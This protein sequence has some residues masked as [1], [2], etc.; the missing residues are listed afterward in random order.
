VFDQFDPKRTSPGGPQVGH[1]GDAALVFVVEGNCA[2]VRSQCHEKGDSVVGLCQS[3]NQPGR[4]AT[5]LQGFDLHLHRSPACGVNPRRYGKVFHRLRVCIV[6][7][8]EGAGGDT[9]TEAPGP[10]PPEPYGRGQTAKVVLHGPLFSGGQNCSAPSPL[11]NRE[12]P[13]CKR[14][15]AP[16]RDPH[17]TAS[18]RFIGERCDGAAVYEEFHLLRSL[19]NF[20]PEKSGAGFH[21]FRNRDRLE[22]FQSF[23]TTPEQCRRPAGLHGEEIIVLRVRIQSVEEPGMG[24]GI[25]FRHGNVD[26]NLPAPILHLRR[27]DMIVPYGGTVGGIADKVG[28]ILHGS[29]PGP[30][31]SFHQKVCQ[32]PER[33]LRHCIAL[34]QKQEKHQDKY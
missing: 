8:G 19:Q 13:K 20:K 3:V 4:S 10:M 25:A 9:L 34:R 21:G 17:V 33:G 12:V 11:P 2:I 27:I 24:I 6:F 28:A 5:C 29:D 30:V 26:G 22:P 7:H 31:R 18:D 15:L 32:R 14:A 1:S 23:R 16:N